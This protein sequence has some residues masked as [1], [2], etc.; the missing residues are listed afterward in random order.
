M[1]KVQLTIEGRI[2]SLIPLLSMMEVRAAET[3]EECCNTLHIEGSLLIDDE[4]LRGN[5]VAGFITHALKDADCYGRY[6]VPSPT[7][8]ER[9]KFACLD[10]VWYEIEIDE[11]GNF[12]FPDAGSLAE[13]PDFAARELD[14]MREFLR[15]RDAVVRK[16]TPVSARYGDTLSTLHGKYSGIMFSNPEFEEVLKSHVESVQDATRLRMTSYDAVEFLLDSLG[17]DGVDLV[18]AVAGRTTATK[19]E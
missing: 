12:T 6:V 8:D 10:K 9:A 19:A 16:L 17:P 18:L 1:V 14:D 11:W 13:L 2:H 4:Y 3:M 15:A 7:G 5:T